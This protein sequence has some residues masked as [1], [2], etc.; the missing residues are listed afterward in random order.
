MGVFN[1]DHLS[2]TEAWSGIEFEGRNM[3]ELIC[4]KKMSKLTNF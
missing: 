1:T 3:L 2:N 4:L